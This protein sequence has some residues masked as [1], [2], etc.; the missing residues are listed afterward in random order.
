MILSVD[1]GKASGVVIAGNIRARTFDVLGA[2]VLEWPDRFWFKSFIR[3]NYQ[4]LKWIVIERFALFNNEKTIRAQIGS[5]FPSV[6][7]IGIIEAWAEE[8]G[9]L[10]RIVYQQPSDIHGR[11]PR[12]GRPCYTVKIA[13]EHIT[14]IKGSSPHIEDAYRHVRYYVLTHH[15]DYQ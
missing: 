3:A 8:Y 7:I 10:D 9:L 2:R 11:D 5:E 12:T 14:Q 6:R 15:K 1:P 13:S 4:A